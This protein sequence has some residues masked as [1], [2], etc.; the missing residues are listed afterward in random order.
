[1]TTL[2][3]DPRYAIQAETECDCRI[4]VVKGSLWRQAIQLV[5]RS[6][7]KNVGFES[8]RVNVDAYQSIQA[9][10]PLGCVLSSVGN[11][12]ENERMIKSD[13]EISQIRQSVATCS[14]AFDRS[15]KE[16]RPGVSEADLAALIDYEMRRLG[17]ERPPSTPSSP[18]VREALFPMRGRPRLQFDPI[19]Y[20]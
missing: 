9:D 12:I 1:M 18:L 11:L 20:Y 19:S 4:R 3:T 2:L 6:R 16:V 13:E 7:G 10:L 15:L 17:A 8:A 5:A 14:A